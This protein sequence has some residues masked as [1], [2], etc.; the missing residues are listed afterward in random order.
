M[1]ARFLTQTDLDEYLAAGDPLA[2]H[3]GQVDTTSERWLGEST[4]KRLIAWELY[5]DLFAS[6]GLRIADIGSGYSSIQKALAGRHD[7][8]AV[9][10]HVHD[11]WAGHLSSDWRDLPEQDF[12]P[13]RESLRE[14]GRV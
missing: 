6:A 10:L 13:R 9:D 3:L 12:D 14:L 2:K 5:G 8:L 1:P 11:T 7:Y 4:A